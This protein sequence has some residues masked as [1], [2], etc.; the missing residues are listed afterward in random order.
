[1]LTARISHFK[2]F[3]CICHHLFLFVF[4]PKSGKRSGGNKGGY[5]TVINHPPGNAPKLPSTSIPEREL[6]SSLAIDHLVLSIT[7]HPHESNKT[8]VLYLPP[9]NLYDHWLQHMDLGPVFYI[10]CKN[11]AIIF[12]SHERFV[13]Y[14][15]WNWLNII[16]YIKKKKHD[17]KN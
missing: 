17:L 13:H 16:T 1:M 4:L 6:I 7:Q 8:K 2:V 9:W 15:V 3:H 5:G 10:I 12:F 14:P 11:R